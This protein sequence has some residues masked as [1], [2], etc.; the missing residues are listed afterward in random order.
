MLL[1]PAAVWSQV[2]VLDVYCPSCGYREKFVQ[3][4]D[5]S[6]RGRNIQR[7]IVV[8]ERAG[9][10]RNIAIPLDPNLPVKDEPLLARQYGTGKSELLGVRLPR[11]LVPGNTCPLFPL[12]AY[13]ERKVCPI[14]GKTGIHY[15]V[16]GQY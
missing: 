11:F 6:D 10:I 14:D 5:A 2:A 12:A 7:I 4:S 1:A 16:V 3:G 15:A 9:Q 13:L 8:C